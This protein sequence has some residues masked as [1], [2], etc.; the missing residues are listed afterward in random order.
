[1]SDTYTKLFKGI[2]ASTIVEEPLATRW[3]WVT[4]LAMAD[5]AGVVYGSVPGLA[6]LANIPLADCEQGLQRLSAPDPH[7]RTREHEGRRIEAIDGGWLILNHG[8]YK[9]IRSAEE[10]R[11]YW[12]DWKAAKRAEGRADKGTE[13]TDCP[14]LSTDSTDSTPPTPSPSPEK[15]SIPRSVENLSPVDSRALAT[16]PPER[17]PEA[18]PEQPRERPAPTPAGAACLAMLGAGI[19]RANPH[20]PRLLELIDAGASTDQFRAAAA[21]A[22]SRGKPNQGYALGIVRSQMTEAAQIRGS[23]TP[24]AKPIPRG[25][26][27]VVAL[28]ELK[29]KLLEERRAK[30]LAADGDSGGDAAIS[31][32]ALGQRASDG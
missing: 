19:H 4:M 25:M 16:Q 15:Q 23:P 1:M 3:L 11:Q 21:D 17:L 31:P 6:R 20:D 30:R 12:R 10:R 5:S 13:S 2:T 28:E 8:K 32:P 24:L 29:T 26:E 9:A 14:Q 18:E 27:G 7:S 22:V